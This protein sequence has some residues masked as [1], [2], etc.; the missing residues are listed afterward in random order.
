MLVLC[1]FRDMVVHVQRVTVMMVVCQSLGVR[2]GIG[3]IGNS[4]LLAPRRKPHQS[5]P[6]NGKDQK[7]GTATSRHAADSTDFICPTG[8]TFI[9]SFIL[10][11]S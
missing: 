9:Q 5:L 6:Q 1:S 8:L 3:Q 2:H 7:G 10:I 4:M 11:T